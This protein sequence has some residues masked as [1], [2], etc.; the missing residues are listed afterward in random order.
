MKPKTADPTRLDVFALAADA[1]AIEGQWP[2]TEMP[3]LAESLA[4]GTAAEPPIH[5]RVQGSQ[6]R[7]AGVDPQTWLTLQARAELALVCQRCLQPV[8]LPVEVDNR[9][10]FVR[11]ESEAAELDAESEHDVLAA[12]GAVDLRELIEDEM[13]MALPYVPRHE[14]CPQPAADAVAEP[15]AAT[16][17]PF[18]ALKG[19]RP[20]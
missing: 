15:L 13:L 12:D 2:V 10:R 14:H 18:E 20:H 6:R 16:H 19:W 7:R 4:P 1:G 8:R 17:R 5:W 11:G 3:R 9:I